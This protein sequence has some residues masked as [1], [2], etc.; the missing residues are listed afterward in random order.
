MTKPLPTAEEAESEGSSQVPPPDA[1]VQP[2]RRCGDCTA[3]CSVLAVGEI[4]KKA[5]TPCEHCQ[6]RRS[7]R[8]DAGCR[9]YVTRPEG[10]RTYQCLWS[11]GFGKTSHRPDKTGVIFDMALNS[12]QAAVVRALDEH[13]KL[14]VMIAREVWNGAFMREPAQDVISRVATR[15]IVIL[16]YA[17]ET[18]QSSIG[19]RSI[20]GPPHI[21]DTVEKVL[22]E[23]IQKNIPTMAVK[24]E[25][26]EVAQREEPGKTEV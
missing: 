15:A 8:R 26:P 16:L 2:K 9:I 12:Q 18:G 7:S 21:M 3:C 13:Y 6:P 19:R 14:P 5:W 11:L 22:I 23:T 17:D 1:K 24:V 4:Q 20:I 25:E 10:C